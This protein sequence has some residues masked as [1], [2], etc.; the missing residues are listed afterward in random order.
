MRDWPTHTAAAAHNNLGA[1]MQSVGRVREAEAAFASAVELLPTLTTAHTNLRSVRAG[2][3][4]FGGER[5]RLWL[6]QQP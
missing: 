5:R 1:L 2:G 4:H 6:L 3:A